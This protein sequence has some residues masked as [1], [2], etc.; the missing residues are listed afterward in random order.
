MVNFSSS[1]F[2]GISLAG[3]VQDNTK[4]KNGHAEHER[5][6]GNSLKKAVLYVNDFI[7]ECGCFCC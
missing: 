3:S 5:L 2:V 4:K 7:R 6:K 1:I